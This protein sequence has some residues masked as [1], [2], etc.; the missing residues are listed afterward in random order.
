MSDEKDKIDDL[1]HTIL[2]QK[3]QGVRG[4]VIALGDTLHERMNSMQTNHETEFKYIKEALEDI[5]LTSKETLDQAK[6]TNGRVTSLEG[7]M[8]KV[9]SDVNE[10][11]PENI[12]TIEKHT[13]VIRFMH[14]YPV[15][16]LILILSAYLSTIQEVREVVG[17]YVGELFHW[18]GKVL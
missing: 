15:V 1:E 17:K 5:K 3:L 4:Q 14:K 7:T 2:E 11:I 8:E 12:R 6:R 9:E 10:K 16:T 13:K 18:I